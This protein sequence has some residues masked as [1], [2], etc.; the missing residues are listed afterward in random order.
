MLDILPDE[1][2]GK[3]DYLWLDP[4]CKSGIFL[5]EAAA[6]LLDGLSD[7]IPN[8][9]ERRDHI[10]R[11]MLWGTSITQMTGMISRRSLYCSRNASGPASVVHFDH[12]EGN[13]TYLPAEHEWDSGD[14]CIVCRA[15]KAIEREGRENH[16]Y[17]LIH[18]TYPT[19]EMSDM[20]FDVIVGNPPYQIGIENER[21]SPDA[22][23]VYQYFVER[24]IDLNPLHLVMIIKSGWFTGGKAQLDAFRTRMIADRRLEKI[25]DNPKLFD[26]FPGVEIKGGVNYF[27]WSRDHDG[28][29][30]FST[31]IN[32]SITAT[33]VRDLREGEG[34]VVRDNNAASIIQKVSA[35]RAKNG[36][37]ENAVAPRY[38]FGQT[39]MSNFKDAQ[40]AP[41]KGAIP[42]IFGNKVGY[43]RPDQITRNAAWVDKWKV[44]IPKA[45]DGHG[46]PVSYVLGEPI[47]LAP[48]SACTQTYLVAGT[49]DT[50]E[51]AENYA[52][53]LVTRFARFLILQRKVTQ[54]VTPDRFRFVPMMDMTRRWT[55]N[56]LYEEFELDDDERAYIEQVIQPRAVNLSLDNPVPASHLAGGVQF[57]TAGSASGDSDD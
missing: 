12:P 46:R 25:I 31:R 24:A 43:I 10:Y 1:V 21:D 53:Y 45:S 51:E 56:D 7:Q 14:K 55:D 48:G 9:E 23:P 33:A 37:L 44:L 27:L 8:F 47:A 16:A 5:R 39:L 6:R 17:S 36:T 20:K 34:V 18:G 30:E 52:Y 19:K 4:F 35:A 38:P 49:F 54:D 28:D 42:L 41:F 32:G 15:P 29:C 26:C 57:N 13:L 3:A 50:R 40:N 22:N 11:D 2:W